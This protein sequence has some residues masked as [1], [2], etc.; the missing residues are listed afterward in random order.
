MIRSL[1]LHKARLLTSRLLY[2]SKYKAQITFVSM[3]ELTK[4]IIIPFC[5][6][7][8]PIPSLAKID[9]EI[10]PYLE[11]AI[12]KLITKYPQQLQK[13]GLLGHL[14]TFFPKY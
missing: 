4:P 10:N 1:Y 6:I 5:K 8:R 2:R 14:K 7:T 12:N 11:E 13:L 3:Q 9:T